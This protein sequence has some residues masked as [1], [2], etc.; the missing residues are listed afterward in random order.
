LIISTRCF[1]DKVVKMIRLAS[2]DLDDWLDGATRK[3]LVLSGARQV[4]KTWLV[5]NLAKRWGRTLVELNME[6]TPLMADLSSENRPTQILQNW[7]VQN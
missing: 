1:F 2:N 3:P 4:G 6:R 7:A 5:R